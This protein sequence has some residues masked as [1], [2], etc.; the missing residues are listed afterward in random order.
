MR[1]VLN[2]VMAVVTIFALIGGMSVQAMPSA[3]ALGLT[4]PAQVTKADM[5]C[6]R[7]AAER[8]H[9]GAPKPMPCKGNMLDCV[10]QMGC[11]GS[12]NLPSRCHE[13]QNAGFVHRGGLLV[14]NIRLVRTP[15]RP[16]TTRAVGLSISLRSG[17]CTQ[18]T[19]SSS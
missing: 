17:M 19:P 8:A 1:A 9:S 4:R 2:R 3:E 10:K 5:D 18:R 16:A 14:A 15:P 11:I 13:V 6:P 12:P 7:M